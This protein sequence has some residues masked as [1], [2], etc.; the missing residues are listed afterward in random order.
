MCATFE[1]FPM[2]LQFV[3]APDPYVYATKCTSVYAPLCTN[4]LD[5]HSISPVAQIFVFLYIL[6]KSW[7]MTMPSLHPSQ[8]AKKS[9]KLTYEKD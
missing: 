5:V 1:Y 3:Y 2:C 7:N 6:P 4:T 8:M 9:L